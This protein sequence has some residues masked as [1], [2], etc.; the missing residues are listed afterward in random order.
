M[1]RARLPRRTI[2]AAAAAAITLH[3]K[4][5]IYPAPDPI[6]TLVETPSALELHIGTA[7]RAIQATVADATTRVHGVVDRWIGVEHAVE[8]RVKSLI[9]PTEPL[10]PGV[11]YVGIATLTGSIL[12]RS[13]ALPLRIALPP[14]LLVLSLQQFLPKTASNI[15]AY[16]GELEERFFPTLAQKHAVANAHTAMAVEMAKDRARGS[17]EWLG[18]AVERG[19][20][21]FQDLSGLKVREALGWGQTKLKEAEGEAGSVLAAVKAKAT[22]A[23]HEV[24]GAVDK[25][26]NK[27]EETRHESEA[28]EPP[29]KLV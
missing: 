2:L 29:K 14:T 6:I 17:R 12:A 25:L 26:E 8:S 7:R 18:G 10:T 5:S 11:L 15:S 13:R 21:K 9:D 22:N 24:E 4:P 20:D 19:V 3:E 23:A 1:L 16:G 28:K 27:V